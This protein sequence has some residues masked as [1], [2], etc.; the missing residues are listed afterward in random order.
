MAALK[1]PKNSKLKHLWIQKFFIKKQIYLKTIFYK[2]TPK[3]KHLAFR[4][5]GWKKLKYK[6]SNIKHNK[7]FVSG[8]ITYLFTI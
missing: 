5:K 2:L 1:S 6:S 7:S 8:T 3:Y 4:Y